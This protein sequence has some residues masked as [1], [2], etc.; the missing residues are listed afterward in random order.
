MYIR[1]LRRS[2]RIL[3]V[4]CICDALHDLV[5]FVKFKKLKK[6]PWRSFSRFSNCTN[7]NK[8]CNASHLQ[9]SSCSGG[10]RFKFERWP[11]K[12]NCFTHKICNK[13]EDHNTNLQLILPKIYRRVFYKRAYLKSWSAFLS[14]SSSSSIS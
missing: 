12:H 1:R 14:S 6:H 8:S 7:G 3:N 10:S 4:L 9:F 2:G 11:E 13:S 5:P